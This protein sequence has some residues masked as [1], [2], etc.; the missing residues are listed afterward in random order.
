MTRQMT[1]LELTGSI[2]N[3]SSNYYVKISKLRKIYQQRGLTQDEI[4]SMFDYLYDAK[5][6]IVHY[7]K[8]NQLEEPDDFVEKESDWILNDMNYL[9]ENIVKGRY[10][11]VSQ[12]DAELKTT[13]GKVI[14]GER[15]TIQETTE[16]NTQKTILK[17]WLK[18]DK[19][20]WSKNYENEYEHYMK[21][22]NYDENEFDFS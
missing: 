20:F 22:Y 8:Q 12:Y 3:M 2:A 1:K 19:W 11:V 18:I 10:S 15:I 4:E 5:D 14:G 17:N 9:I 7:S 21:S 13:T 16:N 6:A